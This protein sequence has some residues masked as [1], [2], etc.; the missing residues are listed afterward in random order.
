[1]TYT[2]LPTYLLE[3]IDWIVL[4]TIFGVALPTYLLQKGIQYC[5]PFF[6]MMTICFIPVFTFA[7]QLFDPRIEWSTLSLIGIIMLFLLG[8]A[9]IYSE[10]KA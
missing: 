2:I 1:M 3:N 9:S 8:V 4:V 6:V 10:S 7:F 5:E